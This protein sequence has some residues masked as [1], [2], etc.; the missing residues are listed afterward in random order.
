MEVTCCDVLCD[1]TKAGLH[2]IWHIYSKTD[3]KMVNTRSLCPKF[4]SV[5]ALV[6]PTLGITVPSQPE[7]I[8]RN[9]DVSI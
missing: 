5:V 7:T 6:F 8:S 3:E 9:V 1:C 4:E 2:F